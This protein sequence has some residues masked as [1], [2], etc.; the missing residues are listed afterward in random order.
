MNARINQAVIEGLATMGLGHK[1]LFQWEPSPLDAV[2]SANCVEQKVLRFPQLD[3]DAGDGRLNA[4]IALALL[5]VQAHGSTQFEIWP[6]GGL[7]REALAALE[8]GVAS[9]TVLHKMPHMQEK[10]L[11]L[12]GHLL[13]QVNPEAEES[14]RFLQCMLISSLE[15][16]MGQES[17]DFWA[18]QPQGEQALNSYLRQ[19]LPQDHS[20]PKLA[21]LVAILV[22]EDTPAAKPQNDEAPPPEAQNQSPGE[23]E[24]A[25][26]PGEGSGEPPSAAG[27]D[28]ANSLQNQAGENSEN[29]ENGEGAS[30]GSQPGAG[31]APTNDPAEASTK[32]EAESNSSQGGEDQGGQE[33]TEDQASSES[34]QQH[35][36][37]QD[38]SPEAADEKSEVGET[39]VTATEH[40]TESHD[41]AETAIAKVVD[42][43]GS[44]PTPETV[45]ESIMGLE[46]GDGFAVR[47]PAIHSETLSSADGKLVSALLM[48]LQSKRKR[49]TGLASAGPRVAANRLWRLKAMGDTLVFRKPAERDGMDMAVEI[50]LDRSSS[51]D[52]KNRITVARDVTMALATALNRM[53][54]V[55]SAVDVFPGYGSAAHSILPFGGMLN[56]AREEMRAVFASGGTPLA[57]ALAIVRPVLLQQRKRRKVLVVITDGKPQNHQLA[58]C[59]LHMCRE[60]GIEVYAIGIGVD[61]EDLIPAS[62]MVEAVEELPGAVTKIFNNMLEAA[63]A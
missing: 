16:G 18:A 21:E 28:G 1:V 38:T 36:P 27:E 32:D 9:A 44:P 3:D 59:Q 60:M 40:E 57:E 31:E 7:R 26:V 12:H 58:M 11:A 15:I 6:H 55:Q 42:E 51:M 34:T 45:L 41:L 63:T 52:T 20:T 54:G 61:V 4:G 29:S 5:G 22:A 46:G 30:P 62:T 14:R 19:H 43:A 39:V 47:S 56:K 33:L 13:S 2:H 49:N 17:A 10:L 53:T 24:K 23:S 8:L 37:G 25:S 48:A 50:L 35:G